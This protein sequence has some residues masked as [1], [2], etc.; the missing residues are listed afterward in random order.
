MGHVSRDKLHSRHAAKWAHGRKST[1]LSF[2]K[3][4]THRRSLLR[5]SFSS[6]SWFSF[7]SFCASGLGSALLSLVVVAS[8]DSEDI[9][10]GTAGS[11]S[12]VARGTLVCAWNWRSCSIDVV[13]TDCGLPSNGFTFSSSSSQLVLNTIRFELELADKSFNRKIQ[14]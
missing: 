6:L 10:D 4:M 13:D 8:N 1:F 7:S 5:R 11:F 2:V 3:Q 9:T 14:N 12:L